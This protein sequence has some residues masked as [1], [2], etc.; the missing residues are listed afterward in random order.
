MDNAAPLR[1][2]KKSRRSKRPRPHWR[3]DEYDAALSLLLLSESGGGFCNSTTGAADPKI[4][5]PKPIQEITPSPLIIKIKRPKTA[6]PDTPLPP[7]AYACSMCGKVFPCSQAL[8]GHMTVHRQKKGKAVVVSD[9]HHHHNSARV[10]ECLVCH[11]AFDSGQAL[12]GHM[13]KHYDKSKLARKGAGGEISSDRGGASTSGATASAR[14][15]F[16]FDLNL[17]APEEED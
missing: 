13:R 9:D 17:P 4:S 8:G 10:H 6:S 16:M 5:P 3:D 12:G 7:P 2:I 15:M 1:W 11:E 14:P